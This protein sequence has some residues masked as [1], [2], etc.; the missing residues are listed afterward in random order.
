MIR[1]DRTMDFKE[2]VAKR[3][4]IREFKKDTI[5]KEVIADIIKER[6]YYV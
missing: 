6:G 2:V 1:M 3:R 4:S 5:G